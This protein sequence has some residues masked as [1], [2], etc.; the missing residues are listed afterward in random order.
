MK[1][2]PID[3]ANFSW[4]VQAGAIKPQQD[5]QDN[6]ATVRVAVVLLSLEPLFLAAL[7]I[8]DECL[9][10]LSGNSTSKFIFWKLLPTYR[11]DVFACYVLGV[12]SRS[13]RCANHYS[14]H[15]TSYS[16]EEWEK[17]VF[18]IHL[19]QLCGQCQKVTI[20]FI[21]PAFDISKN[22][23][24]FEEIPEGTNSY[25]LYDWAINTGGK[26]RSLWQFYGLAGLPALLTSLHKGLPC[27]FSALLITL[28]HDRGPVQMTANTIKA[29]LDWMWP[30]PACSQQ[31]V[32]TTEQLPE[33]PHPDR[34]YQTASDKHVI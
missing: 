34:I 17:H 25:S 10:A 6:L 20:W 7:N 22:Y 23:V 24:P 32:D 2:T 3:C 13:G 21:P 28:Y 9:E 33:L 26:W 1:Q 29:A 19:L 18:E 12:C 31:V 5:A 11:Q 8:W 30:L 4:R 15:S 27:L 16:Y 14:D